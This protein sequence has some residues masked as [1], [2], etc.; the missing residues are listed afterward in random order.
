MPF[1][2]SVDIK[3]GDTEYFDVVEKYTGSIPGAPAGQI[4]LYWAING[5]VATLIPDGR[6]ELEIVARG[7]DPPASNPAKFVVDFDANGG[8]TFEP[9]EGE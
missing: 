1:A 6:Y 3:P 5:Q 2:Q 7:D 4:R 8:L 9:L